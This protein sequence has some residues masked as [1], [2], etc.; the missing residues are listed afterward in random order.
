MKKQ[1]YIFIGGL[2]SIL[3][4]FLYVSV[5]SLATRSVEATIIQFYDMWYWIAILST[6]FGI[7]SGLYFYLRDLVKGNYRSATG[8][9]AASTGTSS[10]GMV[11]CCAHHLTEILPLVGFSG[12]AVFLTQYQVPFIILGI[13][14]NIGGIMYMLQVIKTFHEK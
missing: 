12:V 1:K 10:V 11:A 8:I 7:Q 9:T 4:L 2:A 14:M 3:L 6:G 13:I 5:M